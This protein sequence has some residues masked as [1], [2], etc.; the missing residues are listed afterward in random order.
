[1]SAFIAVKNGDTI[2]VG[3][4]TL[5]TKEDDGGFT[6]IQFVSKIF[7]IIMKKSL[8][9]GVGCLETIHEW[10]QIAER[11]IFA[12][13]ILTLDQFSTAAMQKYLLP[14]YRDV[15]TCIYQYGFDL[16]GHPHGFK[17]DSDQN[18]NSMEICD[19]V[20][21]RPGEK[22]A[23]DTSG[24]ENLTDIYFNNLQN[25]KRISELKSTNHRA[26]IGGAMQIAVLTADGFNTKIDRYF[27][28]YEELRDLIL[29]NIKDKQV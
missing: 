28:D 27:D 15:Y 2:I 5:V 25:L 23:L 13:N 17:Y 21:I 24:G 14:K 11:N 10:A 29:S 22:S 12:D 8:I 4:D 16:S 3:A 9:V 19:A 26:N 1:M 7:P 6:P 20:I 18:Y